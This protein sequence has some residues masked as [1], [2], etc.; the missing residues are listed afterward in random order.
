MTALRSMGLLLAAC[1]MATTPA[2]A[3]DFYQGK[4]IMLVE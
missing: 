1:V 3:D 4:R 2:A